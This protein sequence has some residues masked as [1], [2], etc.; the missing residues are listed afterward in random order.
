M[1][2]GSDANQASLR[3]E[4]SSHTFFSQLPSLNASYLIYWK[5]KSYELIDSFTELLQGFQWDS[6]SSLPKA[7]AFSDIFGMEI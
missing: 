5:I 1:G 7:D 2:V 6:M 3:K 4:A